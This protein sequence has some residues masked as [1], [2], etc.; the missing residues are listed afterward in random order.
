[1]QNYFKEKLKT[2]TDDGRK[3]VLG[4]VLFLIILALFFSVNRLPK[5]DIV[6]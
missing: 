3:R 4:I 2:N 6:G 1:M 5:L